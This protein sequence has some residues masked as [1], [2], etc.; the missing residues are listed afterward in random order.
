M[1][2]ASCPLS[3]PAGT[4]K[5]YKIRWSNILGKVETRWLN[6]LEGFPTIKRHVGRPASHPQGAGVLDAVLLSR[7]FPAK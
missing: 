4:F 6:P 1:Q 5:A 7:E 3:V 2:W